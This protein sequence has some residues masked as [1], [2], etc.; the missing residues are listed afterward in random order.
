[1]NRVNTRLV[2]SADSHDEVKMFDNI[3]ATPTAAAMP[4]MAL[5]VF[6]A[7]GCR[8]IDIDPRIGSL[9]P[10]RYS[11]RMMASSGTN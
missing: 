9:S 1:M 5:F 6:G 3:T 8:P 10:R 11:T 7:L 4:S 2:V